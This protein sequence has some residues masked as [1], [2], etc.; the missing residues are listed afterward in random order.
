MKCPFCRSS[1]TEVYNTRTTKFAS[2]IW[3][4][5]RCQ[6]CHESF[7][8]YEAADLSFLRVTAGST[9][10]ASEPQARSKAAHLPKATRF[11]RARLF[12]S[13]Y[14][15]FLDVPH[16]DTTINAVTD[17]IETKLLDLQQT[18]ITT[19]QIAA[20]VLSTLKHFNTP[21]FL[22]YLSTHTE[23]ATKTQLNQALKKY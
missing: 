16:K 8:T 21:A 4:R 10:T 13:L 19:Q 2:Q 23:L 6:T 9:S 14:A 22:R 11:S 12:S 7:T 20:I 18:T 1:A 17:T 5:R 3:R 15:A